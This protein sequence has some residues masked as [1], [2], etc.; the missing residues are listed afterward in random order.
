MER[1][2]LYELV[3]GADQSDAARLAEAR[4]LVETAV[5]NS[6]P[7]ATDIKYAQGVGMKRDRDLG[8]PR[9]SWVRAN[10]QTD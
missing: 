1:H 7:T 3:V 9:V 8:Y 6:W 5:C 10:F 4:S 2:I